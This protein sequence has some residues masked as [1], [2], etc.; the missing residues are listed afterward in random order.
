MRTVRRIIIEYRLRAPKSPP[1]GQPHLPAVAGRT[2]PRG[3]LTI[4]ERF[5]KFHQANP[6]VYA[7]LHALAIT[8]VAAGER[9][10]SVKCLYEL[11]RTTMPETIT[12]EPFRLNNIF[13]RCYADLL[14]EDPLLAARIERR[15]R[16][17]Q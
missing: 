2:I 16:H 7:S 6:E 11:L 9:R 10:I 17:A 4:D 8:Q 14:A 15:Q 12:G 5:A 1:E 3:E 13:T